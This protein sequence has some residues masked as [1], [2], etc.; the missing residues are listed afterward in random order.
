MYVYW[1]SV[2]GGG[3]VRQ[4]GVPLGS[5]VGILAVPLPHLYGGMLSDLP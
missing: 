2:G 5:D 4:T 3:G 1:E